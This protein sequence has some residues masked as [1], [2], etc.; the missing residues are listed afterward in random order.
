VFT[1][2]VQIVRRL[3][4]WWF[5]YRHPAQYVRIRRDWWNNHY[6]GW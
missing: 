4:R 5:D 2:L 1:F 6:D 3:W